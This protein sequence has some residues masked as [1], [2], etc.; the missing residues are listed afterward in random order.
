MN[1]IYSIYYYKY[2]FTVDD[3]TLRD[4]V[5]SVDTWIPT[6]T[7]T[8]G[9]CVPVFGDTKLTAYSVRPCSLGKNPSYNDY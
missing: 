3:T 5:Y 6:L 4:R 2:H 8:N 9:R 7:D 1:I